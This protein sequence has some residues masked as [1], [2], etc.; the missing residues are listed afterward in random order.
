MKF[1]ISKGHFKIHCTFLLVWHIFIL[2]DTTNESKK[3]S[4]NGKSDQGK[5]DTQK[6]PKKRKITKDLTVESQVPELT[7]KELNTLVEKELELIMQV[8]L[9]KERADAINAVEEY[10]YDM[11]DK[12]HGIFQ[13]YISEEVGFWHLEFV[14]C[15]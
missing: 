10:V 13:D 8:K 1:D 4:E 15:V 7:E 2:Q 6:K 9:E 12:I 14:T 3:I 5:A 11:R